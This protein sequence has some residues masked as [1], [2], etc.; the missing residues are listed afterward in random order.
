[1]C[2]D[3]GH[4]FTCAFYC[5]SVHDTGSID[6]WQVAQRHVFSGCV[7]CINPGGSVI[8]AVCCTFLQMHILCSLC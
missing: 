5:L 6:R 4:T 7:P 2:F 3:S 8:L 1:M